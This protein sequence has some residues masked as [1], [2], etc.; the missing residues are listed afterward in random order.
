[1]AENGLLD[2]ILLVFPTQT[3]VLDRV[4]ITRNIDFK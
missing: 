3:T 4:D 2:D 1:M